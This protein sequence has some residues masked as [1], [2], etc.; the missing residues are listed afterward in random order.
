M[1][2]T[3]Q[4]EKQVFWVCFSPNINAFLFKVHHR[5]C[6]TAP[7]LAE[8]FIRR[9]RLDPNAMNTPPSRKVWLVV[10]EQR[11]NRL[12]HSN[13]ILL[14]RCQCPLNG[15]IKNHYKQHFQNLVTKRKISP[16]YCFVL[17]YEDA[18]LTEQATILFYNYC[19]L[20]KKK[21]EFSL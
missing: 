7:S 10:L 11:A 2:R 17:I 18:Y 14:P 20:I 3:L 5:Y 1:K 6:P 19:F 21:I 13:F 16:F 12:H 4:V 9:I 15:R 8:Y